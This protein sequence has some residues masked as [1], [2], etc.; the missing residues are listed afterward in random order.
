[1]PSTP[2]SLLLLDFDGVLA[3][4]SRPRRLAALATAAACTPQRVQQ[5][6]F[7]QGLE[8]A[9]DAGAIDTQAYLTQLSNG[10][11]QPIDRATWIAARV[12]ACRADPAAVAQVLAV[13][14]TTAVAVLTNNGPLMA[15]AIVQIVPSLFPLLQGRILCSGALGGRKP[16][17]EVYQRALAQLDAEPARTLFVDDLF[18]NVRGARAAGLHADTVRDARALRRV[19]KRYGLG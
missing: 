10:L 5:V 7:E 14:T 12:A 6:L 9:Y 2:P 18:V 15:E 19:L 1:M 11:G 4:Y 8:R 3:S 17:L 13:S 16:Q